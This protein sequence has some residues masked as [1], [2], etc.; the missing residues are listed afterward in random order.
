MS[1]PRRISNQNKQGWAEDGDGQKSKADVFVDSTALV[2]DPQIIRIFSVLQSKSPKLVKAWLWVLALAIF[3]AWL[4]SF[5]Y[6]VFISANPVPRFYDFSPSITVRVV[7]TASHA[8]VYLAGC[9]VEAVFDAVCWAVISGRRGASLTTFLATKKDT[10]IGTVASLFLTY[11]GHQLWCILRYFM[12]YIDSHKALNTLTF[13]G[14]LTL[15]VSG[16]LIGLPLLSGL[17]YKDVYYPSQVVSVVGGI[18]PLHDSVVALE[19]ASYGGSQPTFQEASINTMLISSTNS[20]LTD[21]KFVTSVAPI[22]PNCRGPDCKSLF[23]PGGL[24]LVLRA[25]GTTLFDGKEPDDPVIIVHDAP[26]Y[27]IEFLPQGFTFNTAVDC[28]VYGLPVSALYACVAGRNNTIFSGF[29]ICPFDLMSSG[30][31][32][33]D[34]SWTK[35]LQ[36]SV[37]MIIYQ[38]TSTVAYDRSNFSILS[39]E[40]LGP[41]KVTSDEDSVA[42]LQKL[43][44]IMYPQLTTILEDIET[45]VVK[46]DSSQAWTDLAYLASV[47]CLQA[48]ITAAELFLNHGYPSWTNGHRD[49]LEGFLAIPVQFGTLLLQEIDKT[50]LLTG[51]MTTTA[52][53]ARVSFRVR[54]EPWALVMFTS[55]VSGLVMCAV[56]PLLYAHWAAVRR[57]AGPELSPTL[58]A[59]FANG[60]PFDASPP[61]MWPSLTSC[62]FGRCRHNR[63]K[64]STAL[65]SP[66]PGGGNNTHVVARRVADEVLIAVDRDQ[67]KLD[68]GSK[69][70]V[71]G[72]EKGGF[73]S[74]PV[75]SPP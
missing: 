40:S 24:E 32:Q 23:L 16:R 37:A 64:Y 27:Q 13:S 46:F 26:G 58:R 53:F 54:S 43:F 41:A 18:A 6:A 21:P 47:Y 31:C 22:S 38:R 59:A 55:V 71:P 9:M 34:L 62:L 74:W 70:T 60:N 28:Q 33:S 39:V 51:G 2:T 12:A 7:N 48:E 61:D 56:L 66:T 1:K 50:V 49:I 14:R 67:D 20:I 19:K 63:G 69:T 65:Q 52:S 3:C 57:N 36:A 30:A 68:H 44:S 75:G 45:S 4:A 11:G 72:W 29:T 8:A 10:G 5:T 25:D 35:D 73:G 42:D 15:M 17:S